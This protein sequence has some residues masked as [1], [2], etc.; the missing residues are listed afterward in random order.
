MAPKYV[1]HQRIA[2]NVHGYQDARRSNQA[3]ALGEFAW[4]KRLL[5]TAADGARGNF[6]GQH[7]KHL[8]P[9]L[10]LLLWGALAATICWLRLTAAGSPSHARYA[11][12][13][14]GQAAAA[15]GHVPAAVF[16]IVYAPTGVLAYGDLAQLRSD[17]LKA[18]LKPERDVAR[19]RGHCAR[20]QAHL[21]RLM[22]DC[23]IRPV[24]IAAPKYQVDQALGANRALADE[25]QAAVPMG[26]GGRLRR[27]RENGHHQRPPRAEP[28]KLRNAGAAA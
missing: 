25:T 17:A 26:A 19:Q 21:R 11:G 4:Q 28:L 23:A 13:D 27:H 9:I 15:R 5:A 3:V 10:V 16:L 12:T 1:L 14:I 18:K 7:R 24:T 8:A 20:T 6:P 22:K 2:V